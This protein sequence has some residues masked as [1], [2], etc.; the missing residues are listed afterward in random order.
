[1]LNLT[2]SPR[3]LLLERLEAISKL[4]KGKSW[5]IELPANCSG[6]L[7]QN[8][9]GSCRLDVFNLCH[10][11]ITRVANATFQLYDGE[12]D[13]CEYLKE[14]L[15][16]LSHHPL[17]AAFGLNYVET[18]YLTVVVL[19]QVLLVFLTA[20]VIHVRKRQLAGKKHK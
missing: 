12:T 14:R 7:R 13:E 3:L 9:V 8:Y 1:M 11:Q 18:G 19:T 16:D 10:T 17:A 2:C 5:K 20:I 15:G 6:A 4:R